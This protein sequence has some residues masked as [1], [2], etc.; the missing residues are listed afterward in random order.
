MPY[1]AWVSI[2]S[3]MHNPIILCIDD[4]PAFTDLYKAILQKHSYDVRIASDAKTGKE[5][6]EKE[7]PALILL[8]VMMP[9]SDGIRDGFD[10]LERLRKG[11]A[12]AKTP[13]IMISG[14]GGS[15]DEKHGK[16]LGASAYIPKQELSPDTLITTVASL[17]GKE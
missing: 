10:L 4:D 17:L 6:A 14:I 5:L 12:T 3:G 2:K 13:I 9:E 15:D 7:H 11:A 1:T 16:E 8:D